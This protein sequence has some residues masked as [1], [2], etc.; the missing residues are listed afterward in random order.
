MLALRKILYTLHYSPSTLS[1]LAGILLG[2]PLAPLAD[3]SFDADSGCRSGGANKVG[4]GTTSLHGVA[5]ATD[6]DFTDCTV[7]NDEFTKQEWLPS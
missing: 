5:V 7:K 4:M 6:G 1:Q 2:T 3:L